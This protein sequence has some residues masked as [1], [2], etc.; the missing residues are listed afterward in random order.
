MVWP[1]MSRLGA[2]EALRQPLGG[3]VRLAC[4]APARLIV[5]VALVSSLADVP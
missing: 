5:G 4:V 3:T 1:L 2:E